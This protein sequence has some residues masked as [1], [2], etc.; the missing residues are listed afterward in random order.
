MF[1]ATC[2]GRRRERLD[3]CLRLTGRESRGQPSLARSAND[4]IG[5]LDCSVILLVEVG[6]GVSR[7]TG[8]PSLAHRAVRELLNAG[9]LR[10][11][12]LDRRL[13]QSAA[14]LA[15]DLRLR[16]QILCTSPRPVNSL[17]RS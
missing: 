9:K 14:L 12:P 3:Q 7:R 13:A 16:V 4:R 5:G 15:V 17:S 1:G 6:G 2:N 11:I 8:R 10:L